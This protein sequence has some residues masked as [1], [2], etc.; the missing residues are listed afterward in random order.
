MCILTRVI[1]VL[2]FVSSA[3]NF[4]FVKTKTFKHVCNLLPLQSVFFLSKREGMFW[5]Y[6]VRTLMKAEPSR[7][8]V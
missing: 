5:Q 1:A 7:T 3:T 2:V 6:Y 4:T 8:I